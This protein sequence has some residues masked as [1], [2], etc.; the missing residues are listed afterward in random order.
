MFQNE[1]PYDPPDQATWS[2]N[3][4]RGWAA[5]K[6]ADSVTRFEGWGLGS[7]CYFRVNPSIHAARAFEVPVRPNVNLHDL[8]TVSLNGAGVIDHVINNYGPPAQG[9]GTHPVNVVAYPPSS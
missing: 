3:G 8:V 9:P 1:M 6:V 7:Y 2:H 5:F 4:T